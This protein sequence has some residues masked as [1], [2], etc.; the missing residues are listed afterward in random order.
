MFSPRACLSLEQSLLNL[1]AM[2]PRL[3]I[4]IM[5]TSQREKGVLGKSAKSSELWRT[6]SLEFQ[7][8]KECVE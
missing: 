2:R 4:R 5:K 7:E 6:A 3:H 8:L 1:C